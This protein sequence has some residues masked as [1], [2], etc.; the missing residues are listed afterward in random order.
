MIQFLHLQ[1][2]CV[3]GS[4]G[5]GYSRQP[6]MVDCINLASGSASAA[7]VKVSSTPATVLMMDRELLFNAVVYI[8]V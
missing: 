2:R 4:A 6:R 5:C 7:E 1:L 3:G 8:L